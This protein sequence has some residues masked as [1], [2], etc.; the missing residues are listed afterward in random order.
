[1]PEIP[2]RTALYRLYDA[3]NR[4]LYIG[5]TSDPKA[6]FI[7]HATYKNW[8]T[9]VTQKNVTWLE[10]TWRQALAAE[11]AAIRDEKPRF[12]GKHNAV[13]AP[14]NA[15]TWPAIDAP[16]RGKAQALADLVRS[17]II[18]GRW[19]PGMRV[20]RRKDLAAAA[21]VGADTADLAYRNLK[22]E[23]LLHFQHGRGIFVSPTSWW[24]TQPSSSGHASH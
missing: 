14:F 18:S 24:E 3:E 22:K 19:A 23:G 5:I 12:N 10:G 20:P 16:P 15:S 13:I 21:R 4:L 1:M 2:E 17:E 6:R 11:A 8:W 7:S 9:Q